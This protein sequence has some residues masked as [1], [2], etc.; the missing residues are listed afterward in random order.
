MGHNTGWCHKSP[1]LYHLISYIIFY[2]AYNLHS[3]IGAMYLQC[4]T[5]QHCAVT[6][7][8]KPYSYADNWAKIQNSLAEDTVQLNKHSSY[9]QWNN[10]L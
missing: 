1:D 10:F 6:V 5:S 8:H 2:I 7:L 9:Q 3:S 4:I